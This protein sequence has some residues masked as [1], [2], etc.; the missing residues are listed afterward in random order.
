MNEEKTKIERSLAMG[1]PEE[2][3]RVCRGILLDRIHGVRFCD[4]NVR[5]I[6]ERMIQRLD[7]SVVLTAEEVPVTLPADS[8]RRG[9]GSWWAVAVVG[10]VLAMCSWSGPYHK[11]N[12][13]TGLIGSGAAFTAAWKLGSED[14]NKRLT[15]KLRQIK[16]SRLRTSTSADQI[17]HRI[18]QL[19]EAMCELLT[20]NQL[21]GRHAAVSR[22][23]Q[24]LHYETNDPELKRSI[25]TLMTSVGL[26]LM[27]YSEDLA[28]CFEAHEANV[29]EPTTTVC[30]VMN[31]KTEMMVLR[32]IVLFPKQS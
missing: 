5:H 23:L 27:P 31:A 11:F 25:E 19:Q 13:L 2:T 3:A 22:W 1:K 14:E 4:K 8:V 17:L 6:L 24:N 12:P 15:K 7:F 18:D 20:L 29:A 26:K 32:G 10:I 21:E 30:A 28:D 9:G 16:T